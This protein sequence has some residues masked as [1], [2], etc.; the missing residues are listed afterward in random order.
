MMRYGFLILFVTLSLFMF[1]DETAR[2]TSLANRSESSPALPLPSTQP[3][4]APSGGEP[5]TPLF[6]P[7]LRVPVFMYHEVVPDDEQIEVPAT[8]VTVGELKS[9]LVYLQKKGYTAVT[10]EDLY[11]FMTHRKPLPAKPVVITFD[12]GYRSFYELVYPM[13]R[14]LN[15]KASLSLINGPMNEYG[16]Y[17]Y[18]SWSQVREMTGSGLVEIT[19]HTGSHRL[20]GKLTDDAEL[21]NELAGSREE[22]AK[23]LG[24]KPEIIVY[25]VGSYNTRVIQA[26]KA[27]GYKMG[28]TMEKGV[29]KY[30]DSVWEIKR[31]LVRHG[32]TGEDLLKKLN[33]ISLT[34]LFYF[35]ERI[36]GPA[37]RRRKQYKATG[38]GGNG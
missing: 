14:E 15:Y 6:D 20:L 17:Y 10:L 28:I 31:I 33:Y 7:D 34:K 3:G 24:W 25:P 35:L 2:E 13:L 29:N 23:Y 12:D 27:A 36:S 16:A 38:G 37:R 5:A 11:E 22:I 19:S 4:P 21:K 8:H 32:D 9:Q 1:T 26:A 30:G 18:V